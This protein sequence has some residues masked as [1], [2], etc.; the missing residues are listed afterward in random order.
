MKMSAVTTDYITKREFR[1]FCLTNKIPLT[2]DHQHCIWI[3]L[4][5]NN[6]GK[7]LFSNIYRFLK[8]STT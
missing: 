7:V 2:R 1:K 8:D 6:D 5:R 4:D 3:L